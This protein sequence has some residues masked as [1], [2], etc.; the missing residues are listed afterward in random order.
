MRIFKSI[1]CCKSIYEFLYLYYVSFLQE[2]NETRTTIDSLQR[3][4]FTLEE[5]LS[6]ELIN[7]RTEENVELVQLRRTMVECEMELHDLRDQYLI[8]K[9]KAENDLDQEHKRIGSFYYLVLFH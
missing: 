9:A 8:L 1:I 2:L 3:L 6:D 5:K 7:K 4:N